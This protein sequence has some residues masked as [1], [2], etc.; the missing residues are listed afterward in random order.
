MSKSVE[1]ANSQSELIPIQD[2]GGVQAV[3]GRDLHAFLEVGRDY[4]NWM[5]QMINYGFT[6]SHDV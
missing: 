4:T 5:K 6:A 2:N 3:L 1:K